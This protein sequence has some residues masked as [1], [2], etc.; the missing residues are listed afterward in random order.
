L[1]STGIKNNHMMK[2][3]KKIYNRINPPPTPV[4]GKN[5]FIQKTWLDRQVAEA[6]YQQSKN[7]IHQLR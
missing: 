4:Y 7:Q 3:L 2:L 1:K 5:I 6:L